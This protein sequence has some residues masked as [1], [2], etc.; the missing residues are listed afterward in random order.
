MKAWNSIIKTTLD[1]LLLL[2]L[3]VTSLLA[4]HSAWNDG[5]VAKK[6][7]EFITVA[8]VFTYGAAGVVALIGFLRKKN[9]AWI[10]VLVWA[11]FCSIA[12]GLA[13]VVY[14]EQGLAIAAV[15]GISALALV[16]LP[17]LYWARKMAKR[18]AKI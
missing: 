18:Q 15:A 14:G 3:A 1:I 2:V 12:A 10:F 16:G 6:P 9:W 7:G 8:T 11:V 17:C 5:S 13:T 4:F